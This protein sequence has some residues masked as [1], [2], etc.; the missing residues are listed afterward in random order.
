M[1]PVCFDYS[2][3]SNELVGEYRQQNPDD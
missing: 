2:V 3:N 1:I